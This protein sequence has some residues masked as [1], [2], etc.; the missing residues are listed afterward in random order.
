MMDVNGDGVLSVEEL[1]NGLGEFCTFE[2][3]NDETDH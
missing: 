3:F 1:K 2:L